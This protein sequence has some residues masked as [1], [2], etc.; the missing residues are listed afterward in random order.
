M[1][2]DREGAKHIAIGDWVGATDRGSARI[3][4]VAVA[5]FLAVSA[6]ILLNWWVADRPS[7]T[8]VTPLVED[9]VVT[10]WV[11]DA[12]EQLADVE[13]VR[14]VDE[15]ELAS[16]SRE[17]RR[18]VRLVDEEG[19]PVPGTVAWTLVGPVEDR[20]ASLRTGVR[21]VQS[22]LELPFEKGL[23]RCIAYA[24]GRDLAVCSSRLESSPRTIDLVLREC[25]RLSVEFVTPHG[26]DAAP[27]SLWVL[28][29]DT[30]LRDAP[31]IPFSLAEPWAQ[32]VSWPAGES[33]R[34]LHAGDLQELLD[35]YPVFL[36]E[37]LFAAAAARERRLL[38]VHDGR[39]TIQGLPTGWYTLLARGERITDGYQA[40]VLV[41][42]GEESHVKMRVWPARHFRGRVL[43][44]GK[45]VAGADVGYALQS[46]GSS[47]LRTDDEGRFTIPVVDELPDGDGHVH[48][49]GVGG[50]PRSLHL[51]FRYEDPAG[52]HAY[53]IP[54][55]N[56]DLW[57][58][59][60]RAQEFDFPV[61]EDV[62]VV[63]VVDAAGVPLE[64]ASVWAEA[65]CLTNEYGI[66][67]IH[68]IPDAIE[69]SPWRRP[70]A[71]D[72]IYSGDRIDEAIR[73]PGQR[74]LLRREVPFQRH[75]RVVFE[76]I[77]ERRP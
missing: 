17:C 12:M 62:V 22:V 38:R 16:T 54:L 26:L 28:G 31:W 67:K 7:I 68:G 30:F 52:G 44:R 21:N 70:A 66:A 35:R 76:E 77:G 45:P 56:I 20:R 11:P 61:G 5:G 2:A 57:E 48:S 49:H 72:V 55:R 13:L 23:F 64:G 15:V 29:T 41:R 4:A 10:A 1:V 75:V 69:R 24:E 42:S 58:D 32:A 37:E 9:S 6:W 59:W 3:M 18:I 51:W 50:R 14:V 71:I 40:E 19:R 43:L 65:G 25:G 73:E 34:S 33:V 63:E 8:E 53:C 74:G 46:S 36:G 47:Q 60:D 39:I 27:V